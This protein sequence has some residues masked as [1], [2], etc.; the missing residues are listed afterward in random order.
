MRGRVSAVNGV[1]IGISNELGEFESGFVAHLFHDA[2]DLAFGPTVAVV[3]GGLG[4]ILVVVI[5]CWLFPEVRRCRT[6]DEAEPER[7]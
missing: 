2:Q 1:F 3:S 5:A 4:T 7:L 6:L